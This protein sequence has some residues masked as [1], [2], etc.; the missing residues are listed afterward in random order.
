MRVI[1]CYL[2]P[3]SFNQAIRIYD[4]ENNVVTYNNTT[5]IT[6]LP[7]AVSALAGQNDIQ[8]VIVKCTNKEYFEPWI[9][10]IK[11]TYAL[12][13]NNNNLEIEVI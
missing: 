12:N 8:K 4:T 10:E 9:E 3:F 13:Y 7:K 2:E 11:T 5:D 6:N 1:V